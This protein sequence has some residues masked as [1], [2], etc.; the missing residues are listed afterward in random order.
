MGIQGRG[1]AGQ[2]R[3]IQYRQTKRMLVRLVAP[4]WQ[5]HRYTLELA[6]RRFL[7]G[8]H[9]NELTRLATNRL[10]VMAAAASVLAAATAGTLPP[11]NLADVEA[12][13]GGFV[14]RGDN[15]DDQSGW[16]VSGAGDVNGDGLADVVIGVIGADAGGDLNAGES[17][18]VFGK[19]DG[20]AVNLSAVAAGNG[21]F[22]ISGIDPH[23][24]CGYSVSGVGDVNGDELD[25]IVVTASR[26]D[27]GGVN[28]AGESYVV[29][30]KADGTPVDLADVVAGSGGFVINGIQSYDLAGFSVSGAGDVNGDGLDDLIV[31]APYANGPESNSGHSYVVFG[32]ADGAPV[33]L[34]NIVAGN[35]GFVIKGYD[36]G[37]RAG[38]SVSGGG[39]INGDGLD[40]L[41]VGA[42]FA[43]FYYSYAGHTYVVFGKA[44]GAAVSL[45]AVVG[46]NGGFVIT[47]IDDYDASGKAVS[48]AGDVNGDGLADI[49]VGAYGATPAGEYSGES[50]VV[51]GKAGGTP[52]SLADVAAGNG[53][54][55][56]RGVEANA[57]SG[58]AVSGAGD[59]NGDGLDDLLVGAY[60]ATANGNLDAGQTYVILGKA[61]GAAVD[62]ADI[63]A[64][65][66]GWVVNGAGTGD[67]A[68]RS[69]SSAGD[70][71]G[72]GV[73]DIVIGADRG[74][75]TGA[76]DAGKS[77]VVFGPATSVL[78]DLDGDGIV[79]I[80]DFLAL[81]AAWGPCGEPCPPSCA[82]DLDRDCT[83]GI[84]DFLMLLANWS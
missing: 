44:D 18:V 38:S 70:V 16:S 46:G 39:D 9:C 72:D 54:F 1:G 36:F 71:N 73:D 42:P 22:L 10:C 51:F 68:G 12:G 7:R 23:D 21:G 74:S 6:V 40:D 19:A 49:I 32:K 13:I 24:W 57:R 52:V 37:G 47:G 76:P 5:G 4:R 66:G 62:L 48:V 61:D 75:P 28:S 64:G 45:D 59:L 31:G 77:Y 35:G 63:I 53:G 50:Y 78:G 17:Y 80:N 41:I 55:V 79:G 56:I 69:V 29:F 33:N 81:L 20:A 58:R 26:A 8:K 84:Q 65:S 30:G 60:L 83:V 14:I 15:T 27:P 34:A 2:T 82:G 3:R 43:G 25:D 11:V 67:Y